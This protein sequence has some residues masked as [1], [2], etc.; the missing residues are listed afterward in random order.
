MSPQP[1]LN[2]TSLALVSP[3]VQY[4]QQYDIVDVEVVDVVVEVVVVV[5]VDVVVLDVVEIDVET[6]STPILGPL[7]VV[8]VQDSS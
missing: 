8:I 4:L 6:Q 5:D 1:V 3:V 7:L 2:C